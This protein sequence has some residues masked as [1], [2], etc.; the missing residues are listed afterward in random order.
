MGFFSVSSVQ[1]GALKKKMS[2]FLR[3]KPDILYLCPV[4]LTADMVIAKQL[5][6]KLNS[7]PGGR[8]FSIRDFDIPMEYQQAL[9]RTMS[10]LVADGAIQKISKGKYYKARKS[11]FGTLKPPVMEIVKDFLE[12]DGEPTGYITGTAAFAKMGLTTQISSAITIG[13]KQYRRPLKRGE[14]TVSFIFQP[15]DITVENIPLLCI[16]DALKLLNK[17][18]GT[19][20]DESVT[21]LARQIAALPD[22]ERARLT[23]LAVK[24]APYVRALL[25]AILESIGFPAY[26][27]RNS[28]NG[29]TRY[30]IPVSEQ[31]L[32]TKK[33][34]NII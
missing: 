11:V 19:S 31:A 26:A 25:G 20:P 18:P 12:R 23:E 15:N 13:T 16:L 28:L 24:Y 34:W 22:E 27:L 1:T 30:K 9:Q 29:T 3:K 32:P 10:R 17:I 6:E 8:V 21:I 4:K 33:N 2:G 7:I 5:K 14:Y